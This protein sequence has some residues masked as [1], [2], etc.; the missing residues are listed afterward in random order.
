RSGP[1]LMLTRRGWAALAAGLGLYIAA[2]FVGSDDLHMVAVGIVALPF[3][4]ALFVHWNRVRLGIHRN[5]S[6]VRVF[7]GTRVTVTVAVENQGLS[8]TPFLLL[9][10]T[11]PSNLGRSARLVVTGVP[12]G[13][14]QRVSYS[15]VS[16][17]R[18]RYTL[19]PL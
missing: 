14:T 11:L 1:G 19:G 10:D 8:T 3:L 4:S 13:G 9:E 7:P 2:R 12:T 6:A 15:V 17:Q 16:R 5:L 18:G